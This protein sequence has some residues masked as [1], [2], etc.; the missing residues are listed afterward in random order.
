MKIIVISDTHMPRMA[1]GLPPRLKEEL[2]TADLILH[3]GDW[4]TK[5]VYD[6]LLSYAPVD[7]VCGNVDG[8]DLIDQLG[9]QKILTLDGYRIGLVHGHGKKGTTEGRAIEA[10]SGEELDLIIFGHSHIPVNKDINGTI[11]FNPGSPTDKR[12]QTEYSFGIIRIEKSLS[13]EHVFYKNKR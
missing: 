7:G 13:V 11:L 2:K 12:R 10:F 1:K 8:K 5:D 6:E 9:Y 4:Q 3:A